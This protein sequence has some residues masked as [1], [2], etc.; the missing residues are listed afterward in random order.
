MLVYHA[1][2]W[3]TRQEDIHKST[4]GEC[5]LCSALRDPEQ[6]VGHVGNTAI[7]INT[8]PY[9]PGHLLAVPKRHVASIDEETLKDLTEI[10]RRLPENILMFAN[11]GWY[12]GQS[13]YHL[14]VHIIPSPESVRKD[15]TEEVKGFLA[16]DSL[17]RAIVRRFEIFS[18][19]R[20][21]YAIPVSYD[22]EELEQTLQRVAEIQKEILAPADL[23]YL[24]SAHLEFADKI[25]VYPRGW[26]PREK[27]LAIL[28][29]F[30]NGLLKRDLEGMEEKRFWEVAKAENER[31]ERTVL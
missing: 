19:R 31:L 23:P 12:A 24:P 9:F 3:K 18:E 21:M 8:K 16:R 5:R 14:H 6:V 13:L 26:N 30:Y 7:L 1:P 27:R 22:Y 29:L 25:Y 28:E 2:A 17:N 4:E 20:G 15:F 10:R 11:I